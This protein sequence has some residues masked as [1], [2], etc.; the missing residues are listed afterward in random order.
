MYKRSIVMTDKG[1]ASRSAP[2]MCTKASLSGS[3]IDIVTYTG[4]LRTVP[5]EC[6]GDDTPLTFDDTPSFSLLILLVHVSKFNIHDT[7]L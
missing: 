6:H 2:R 7:L 3:V 5:V 1:G 4:I